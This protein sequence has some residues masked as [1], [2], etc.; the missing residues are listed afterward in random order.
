MGPFFFMAIVPSIKE[1]TTMRTKTQLVAKIE[2]AIKEY[3]KDRAGIY[4]SIRSEDWDAYDMHSTC[5]TYFYE[6]AAALQ[7]ELSSMARNSEKNFMFFNCTAADA[8]KRK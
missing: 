6:L 5:A 8:I 4:T 7:D 3:H 2:E 1:D